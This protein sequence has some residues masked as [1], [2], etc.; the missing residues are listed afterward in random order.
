LVPGKKLQYYFRFTGEIAGN[1]LSLAKRI[2]GEETIFRKSRTDCRFSLFAVHSIQVLM[3][4][5]ITLSGIKTNL[6]CAVLRA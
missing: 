1:A 5:Y 3:A 2:A 6:F 4:V